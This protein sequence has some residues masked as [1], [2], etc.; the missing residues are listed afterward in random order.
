MARLSAL[1]AGAAAL[2]ASAHPSHHGHLHHKVRQETSSCVMVTATIDGTAQSWC[3]DWSGVSTS[4]PV[5]TATSKAANVPNVNVAAAATSTSSA[6]ASTATESSSSSSSGTSSDSASAGSLVD[7]ALS[8]ISEFTEWTTLCSAFTEKRATVAEISRVGNIG[9]VYGCNLALTSDGDVADAYDNY[10]EFTGAP[11]DQTCYVWNKIGKDGEG[12]NGFEL[13]SD[14]YFAFSLAAGESKYV[15]IQNGTYGGAACQPATLST[16][17]T[18]S[19]NGAFAYT[20][21]EWTMVDSAS[22]WSDVDASCIQAQLGGSPVNALEITSSS[23]P[24][25]TSSVSSSG[26]THNGWNTSNIDED[27]LGIN[28][29]GT[30]KGTANLGFSG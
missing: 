18:N 1:I 25:V 27:G 28:L 8:V 7:H 15:V 4:A 3:N 23:A 19:V 5:A 11:A 12:V 16:P 30:F 26:A 14:A 17:A 2:G 13:K 9:T 22:G 24:D 21:V 10:V 29:D 20:W 6:A